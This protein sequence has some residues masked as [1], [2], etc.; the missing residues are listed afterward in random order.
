MVKLYHKARIFARKSVIF[1][2]I[3]KPFARALFTNDAFLKGDSGFFAGA[4]RTLDKHRNVP[5][6]GNVSIPPRDGLTSRLGRAEKIGNVL[7][8]GRENAT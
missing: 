3:T 7:F 2:L 4:D 1:Q 6:P 5:V 8:L